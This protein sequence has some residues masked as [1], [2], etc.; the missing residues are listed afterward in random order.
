MSWLN[1]KVSSSDFPGSMALTVVIYPLHFSG[2]FKS[3]YDTYLRTSAELEDW[4]SLMKGR[5]VMVFALFKG[6]I[7]DRSGYV[8]LR[9]INI[10]PC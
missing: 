7:I 2:V 3:G 10:T 1:N 8:W 4:L 9:K 5:T 6:K